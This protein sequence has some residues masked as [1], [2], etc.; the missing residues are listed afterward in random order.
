MKIIIF[1]DN[2]A[3][4]LNPFS[5]N[6]GTFEVRVGAFTNIERFGFV[7]KDIVLIVRSEIEELMKEVFDEFGYFDIKLHISADYD[8]MLRINGRTRKKHIK[9]SLVSMTIGGV[10]TNRLLIKA[11][12][13]RFARKKN[14]IP[15]LRNLLLTIIGIVSPILNSIVRSFGGRKGFRFESTSFPLF[16]SEKI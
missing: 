9:K 13:D 10:S 14:G 7:S 15:F 4:F 8:F 16:F 1:E 5:I 2:K 11:K 12:E 3:S 6:H